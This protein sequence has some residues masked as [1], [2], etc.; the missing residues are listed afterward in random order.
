MKKYLIAAVA[1]LTISV[2][3]ASAQWR[4]RGVVYSPNVVRSYS[5]PWVGSQF[6]TPTIIHSNPATY[7]SVWAS[8][9]GVVRQGFY[10]ATTSYYNPYGGYSSFS[11]GISTGIGNTIINSN[12]WGGSY[13]GTRNFGY[14]TGGA[15][16]PG[17]FIIRP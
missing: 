7:G 8:Q 5:T 6:S 11:P 9:P 2:A 4:S 13:I 14:S 10:P 17:G 12:P 3:D 1:V 16:S 15:F